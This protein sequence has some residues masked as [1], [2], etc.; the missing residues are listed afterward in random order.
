MEAHHKEREPGGHP[1]VK[2]SAESRT[3]CSASKS[4][5]FAGDFGTP[6][7]RECQAQ[8]AAAYRLSVSRMFLSLGLSDEI[9]NAIVDEQGY[10]TP[11]ALTL[12][13][14]KGVE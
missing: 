9:V 11:H 12:I 10:N 4:A 5:R 8:F 13:N 1:T 14:K 3:N 6:R 2:A 7:K